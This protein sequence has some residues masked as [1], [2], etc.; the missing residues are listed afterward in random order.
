[1]I[2]I[3][4]RGA[5]AVAPENTLL[6]I[7]AGMKCADYVEVDI[8]LSRDRVPVV[9][10]DATV[11][12]TTNGS[13][14]VAGL[15]LGE[16]KT[17][18]AGQGE[19][20][21]TLAEVCAT[22]RGRC[23]LFAEI[24]EPGSEEIVCTQL[25]EEGPADLRYV[26]FHQ[27]SIRAVQRY[28]PGA[29]AGLIVSKPSPGL[30]ADAVGLGVSGLLPKWSLVSRAMTAEAHKKGIRVFSWTLNNAE[31]VTSAAEYGIDGFATDDPCRIREY[32][33]RAKK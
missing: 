29:P 22:I 10:H 9:I 24:K 14:P 21:P 33:P 6:A 25:R 1:M 26:S 27:E 15:D 7:R 31:E 20:I 30:I 2:V 32:L 16:L 5:R 13:G 3:G 8:R 19:G 18:D 17:L 23:G 4:H 12:R 11:D 28:H